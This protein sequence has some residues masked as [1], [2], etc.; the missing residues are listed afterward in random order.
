MW[1]IAKNKCLQELHQNDRLKIATSDII[2]LEPS[3]PSAL[4][5]EGPLIQKILAKRAFATLSPADQL[6]VAT[7][8]MGWFSRKEM[9]DMFGY[10]DPE[11]YD[12]QIHRIRQKMR[13]VVQG[14]RDAISK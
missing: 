9:A 14:A 12:R 2:E 8:L 3:N 13:E 11:S 10:D 7:V 4:E 6:M 1:G 5:K